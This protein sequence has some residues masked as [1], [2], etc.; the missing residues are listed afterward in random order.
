ML[1]YYLILLP[2]WNERNVFKCVKYAQHYFF[3]VVQFESILKLLK[4]LR[5][6][7]RSENTKTTLCSKH[8]IMTEFLYY[9]DLPQEMYSN[10][11]KH[12]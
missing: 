1:T 4:V 12:F 11:Y 8:V 10:K 2:I 3:G 6:H 5:M 9:L 7:F